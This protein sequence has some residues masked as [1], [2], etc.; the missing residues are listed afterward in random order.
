MSETWKPIPGHE[1]IYEV[2]DIGRVRSL[3]RVVAR[4][5]RVKGRVLVLNLKSN[6]YSQV[7]LFSGGQGKWLMSHRLVLLAFAGP[8]PE[9]ME[10]CHNDG[11]QTNNAPSNLRWDTRSANQM[12]CVAH[13]T[14]SMSS[15]THCKRGHPFD[16][17]NTYLPA[18]GGRVCRACR[19]ASDVVRRDHK[20]AYTR[21]RRAATRAS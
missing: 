6:G 7:E 5:R 11:D 12:D 17:A 15:K 3:D 19:R 9:G 20:T 13:G 10:A 16:H 1:G 8:C 14:N 2:S 18:R 4:N 21:T